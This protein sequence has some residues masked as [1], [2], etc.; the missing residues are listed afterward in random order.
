M[1]KLI[2]GPL[3]LFAIYETFFG[4]NCENNLT[5]SVK[6]PANGNTNLS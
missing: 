4:G 3:I 5:L 6:I 1:K 2:V